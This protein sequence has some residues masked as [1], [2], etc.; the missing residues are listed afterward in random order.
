MVSQINSVAKAAVLT[1]HERL[2]AVLLVSPLCSLLWQE[3]VGL[4]GTDCG[5]KDYRARLV[6]HPQPGAFLTFLFLKTA[7]H[8]KGVCKV[9][10]SRS[11]SGH[12]CA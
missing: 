6:L 5:W 11:P 8:G 7:P 1:L 12:L 3:A 4:F 9:E 10:M 2:A